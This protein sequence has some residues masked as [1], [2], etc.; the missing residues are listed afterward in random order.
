[1][2]DFDFTSDEEEINEEE[3][4]TTTAQEPPSA[5]LE[6]L[7]VQPSSQKRNHESSTSDSDKEISQAIQLSLQIAPVQQCPPEWI[8]VG[9]KK[10]KKF[11]IVD[12][13]H[14]G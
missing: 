2:D 14:A 3:M 10:G 12:P 13:S 4:E 6:D 9:K 7:S 11:R 5:D 1:M 8:K